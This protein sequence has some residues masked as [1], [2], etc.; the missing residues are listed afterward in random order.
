M[1]VL[2]QA[3]QPARQQST[4][5]PILSGFIQGAGRIAGAYASQNN[6]QSPWGQ[7][8][9]RTMSAGVPL[10]TGSYATSALNNFLG[11]I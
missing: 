1:E 6:Y 5:A 2:P 11:G 10:S 7:I 4:F 3:I 8:G 9:S